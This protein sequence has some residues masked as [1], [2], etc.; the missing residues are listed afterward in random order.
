MAL[1]GMK[2]HTEH[3]LNYTATVRTHPPPQAPSTVYHTFGDDEE[4]L[5]AGRFVPVVRILDA[6]MATSIRA[7]LE[8]M[9]V[10]PL[11]EVQVVG[12]V[13]RVRAPLV[14]VPVLAVSPA[15]L[16]D[17]TDAALESEEEE[18][19]DDDV[20][21]EEELEMFDESLALLVSAALT[22]R[23]A[24]KTGGAARSRTANTSSTRL[25]FVQQNVDAPVPQTTVELMKEIAE[26]LDAP[27]SQILGCRG[28]CADHIE[29]R[30]RRKLLR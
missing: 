8:Q 9:I 4:V 11:P 16:L 7:V 24:A 13:A 19:E 2:H 28:S 27:M 21:E 22:F 17:P 1:A 3:E 6:Q 18:E 5:A 25:P 29:G 30:C 10:P 20:E 26:Q 12:R 14:A 23:A 15:G